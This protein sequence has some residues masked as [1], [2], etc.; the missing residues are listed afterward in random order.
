MRND[1][2]WACQVWRKIDKVT[3]WE[4][5][6]ELKITWKKDCFFSILSNYLNA[7]DSSIRNLVF[8]FF[9]SK[10]VAQNAWWLCCLTQ[11]H[12]Y[13]S[14]QDLCI[15]PTVQF[16][17]PSLHSEHP[18][19]VPEYTDTQ[20]VLRDRSLSLSLLVDEKTVSRRFLSLPFI[21]L[22]YHLIYSSS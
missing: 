1:L 18:N 12:F 15:H 16:R 7:I 8:F 20:G 19:I 4:R 9:M 14:S 10:F 6:L 21:L 13:A 11:G 22:S 17:W 2:L 3:I 5:M